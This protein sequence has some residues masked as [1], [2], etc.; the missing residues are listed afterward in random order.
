MPNVMKAKA[1][2]IPGGDPDAMN[3]ASLLHAGELGQE[4]DWNDRVYQVVQFGSSCSSVAANQLAF[5]QD[6]STY[7]VTNVTTSA[8]LNSVALSHRNNLAGIF[9]CVATANYYGC[10][11]KK[12]HN[13][14]VSDTGSSSVAGDILIAA[15][16]A[17]PI[18]KNLTLGTAPTYQTIGVA[19]A[20]SGSNKVLADIDIADTP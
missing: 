11:L 6:R 19:V 1:I 20:S 10:I 4:F 15:S 7:K 9:R 12:G 2:L 17:S 3:E 5:W 18:A 13:I 16:A 14:Y 8:L